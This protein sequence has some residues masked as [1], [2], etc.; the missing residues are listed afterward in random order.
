MAKLCFKNLMKIFPSKSLSIFN[1]IIFPLMSALCHNSV[2]MYDQENINHNKKLTLPHHKI[3]YF[4]YIYLSKHKQVRSIMR[5]E[6]RAGST[7]ECA[8]ALHFKC[9]HCMHIFTDLL[10]SIWVHKVRKLLLWND[11]GGLVL[12]INNEGLIIDSNL[13]HLFK[14]DNYRHFSIC[15]KKR[16]LVTRHKNFVKVL[17]IISF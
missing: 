16:S 9:I 6:W 4:S 10:L 2:N 15:R 3:L 5:S 1:L 14:F 11:S 7:P 17:Q 12:I 13:S 8:C